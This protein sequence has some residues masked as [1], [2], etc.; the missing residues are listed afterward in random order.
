MHRFQ[1]N[2]KT[3]A[4]HQI[5]D[6]QHTGVKK[7]SATNLARA[8]KNS[9]ISLISLSTSSINC[10]MKSTSL[11]FNILHELGH[12]PT[13]ESNTHSSVWKF[14]IRKDISKPLT[15]FRRNMKKASA[16]WVKNRV[17]LWTRICS[18]SSACL[19]LMLIRTLL[20]DGSM[21]TFSFSFRDTVIGFR[22]ASG[23]EAASISGT[24]C[25]S[26]VWEAKFESVRAAVKEA[27]TARR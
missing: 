7:D 20:M 11:C 27:R 17:N 13:T 25:R 22:S 18:I 3:S 6:G 8:F 15:G 10:M 2:C 5:K 1:S 16:R 12:L 9:F 26:A 24:L 14:V 4:S 21:K 19:I 23:L